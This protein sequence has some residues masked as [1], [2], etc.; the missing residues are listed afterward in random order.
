MSRRV[1]DCITKAEHE[2]VSRRSTSNTAKSPAPPLRIAMLGWA[3]LALQ[4]REGSGY[5]LYVSELARELAQ[6]GHL[7]AFL[8]SGIDY[9]L[10]PVTR[11]QP[12][13]IWRGVA[14]FSILNSP[15]LSTGNEHFASPET[16]ISSPR[17]TALVLDFL[18]TFR[19]H[20][21]HVHALEGF[22]FDLIP[23]IKASGTRVVFTPHN[24]FLLCPQVD[25]LHQVRKVCDDFEGGQRCETCMP[26]RPVSREILA[27]KARL[28]ARRW[29]GPS[30]GQAAKSA[31]AA[32]RR[33]LRAADAWP[34][35]PIPIRE[36]AGESFTPHT[37]ISQTRPPLP[38]VL[39]PP[40]PNVHERLL[41]GTI[42]LRV[43]NRYGTRR[44]AAI[45]A[46][47]AADAILC[48]GDFLRKV[49]VAAGADPAKT[50][51]LPIGQ[52][53]FDLA[54]RHTLDPDRDNLARWTPYSPS[55]LRLAFFGSTYPHKGLATLIAAIE[56]L[57]PSVLSRLTLDVHAMGD[58]APF[59][60]RLAAHAHAATAVRFLGAYDI[61]SLIATLR[62][63]DACIFPNGALENSPFV[64]LES[65]AAGRFVIASRLGAS[66]DLLKS[67]E[68]GL[69]VNP[70]DPDDLAIAITSIIQGHLT[71]PSPHQ[72]RE[73]LSIPTHTEHVTA[74]ERIYASLLGHESASS[75]EVKPL[76]PAPEAA[77][78][79]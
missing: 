39:T 51:H 65:I 74:I 41:D 23:A 4:E 18:S 52:P 9:S 11:I 5:N 28:T 1:R 69:L 10:L 25:M 75:V 8:R 68:S 67:S 77:V 66:R 19:P 20:V 72:I 54:R 13:E 17:L 57:D 30:I 32:L 27:R 47:N 21:V 14:C 37:S 22:P 49:H 53:H 73:S 33:R 48:P 71:L 55:P 6:R 63:I 31:K 36:H 45:D 46:L 59:R 29:L 26:Q 38:H 7:V 34:N 16:Q 58:D 15:I 79:Q 2:A 35:D 64:V 40:N 50:R 61:T 42:Q 43:L 44:R 62:A 70:A 3:R 60:R 76:T 78:T 24:Y 56:R 12:T